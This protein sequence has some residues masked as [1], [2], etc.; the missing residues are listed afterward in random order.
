MG[1][2]EDRPELTDEQKSVL[3][4]VKLLMESGDREAAKDLL[5]KAGIRPPHKRAHGE[6]KSELKK[7]S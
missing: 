2:G 4:E 1:M 5:D 7:Q 6:W 3:D